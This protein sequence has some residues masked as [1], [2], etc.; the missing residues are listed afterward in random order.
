MTEFKLPPS[1]PMDLDVTLDEE[2]LFLD[3]GYQVPVTSNYLDVDF[4]A[5]NNRSESTSTPFVPRSASVNRCESPAIMH[6]SQNDSGFCSETSV[7]SSMLGSSTMSITLHT[8]SSAFIPIKNNSAFTVPRL[9]METLSDSRSDSDSAY[10]EESSI[11]STNSSSA[12]SDS[13]SSTPDSSAMDVVFQA[14]NLNACSGLSSENSS[15]YSS[16]DDLGTLV[17]DVCQDQHMST[18][19][20]SSCES[21]VSVVEVCSVQLEK[22]LP[23]FS[24]TLI[25]KMI[26]KKIGVEQV[27]IVT[28]LHNRSMTSCLNLIFGSLEVQDLCR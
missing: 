14:L 3:T 13:L 25:D 24:K 11:C 7:V 4:K 2:D 28:E 15:R 16:Q 21:Q 8:P 17:S 5:L 18:E 1:L 23:N 22:F 10:E 9:T 26:G 27:D 20:E 6:H 19:S 12:F